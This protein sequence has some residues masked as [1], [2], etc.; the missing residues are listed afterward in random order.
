MPFAFDPS[1]EAGPSR[2][3]GTLHKFFE[4]CLSLARDSDALFQLEALLHLSDKTVKDSAVNSLQK[5]KPGKEMRMNV[6]IGDYEVHS[7]ILDLGSDVNI[8][9]KQT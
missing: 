3:Y 4:R 1:A 2:Q 7:I 5:R 6:Q 8:L 9:I